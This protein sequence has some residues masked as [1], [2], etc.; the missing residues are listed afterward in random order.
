MAED[1]RVLG[2]NVTSFDGDKSMLSENPTLFL[3]ATHEL[4]RIN[5]NS[6]FPEIFF[7]NVFR[8]FD[9]LVF[10]CIWSLGKS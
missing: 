5:S 2:S 9:V 4:V 1:R 10:R 7:D 6:G 3:L 8:N